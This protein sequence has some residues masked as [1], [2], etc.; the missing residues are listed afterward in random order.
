MG[1]GQAG[2]LCNVDEWNDILELD[3]F[4]IS[5]VPNFLDKLD[6][7][8]ITQEDRTYL[9]DHLRFLRSLRESVPLDFLL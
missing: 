9:L 7:E 5:L 1:K 4:D 6:E 8:K 3:L 2:K